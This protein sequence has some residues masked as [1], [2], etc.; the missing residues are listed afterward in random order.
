MRI[1]SLLL[2]CGLAVAGPANDAADAI[3]KAL[4]EDKPVP[5]PTAKQRTVTWLIVEVLC[6]RGELDAAEAFAKVAPGIDNEKLPAYVA[7]WRK[8]GPRKEVLEARGEASLAFNKG[9]FAKALAIIDQVKPTSSDVYSLQMLHG[10]AEVLQAVGRVAGSADAFVAAADAAIELG[11]LESASRSLEAAGSAKHSM[12]DYAKARAIWQRQ[13]EFDRRRGAPWTARTVASLGILQTEEGDHRKALEVF[14]RALKEQVETKDPNAALTR[15]YIGMAH[16]RLDEDAEALRWYEQAHKEL[17]ALGARKHAARV[18]ANIGDLHRARRRYDKAIEYYE[19]ALEVH[20][21]V[22]SPLDVAMGLDRLAT[23]HE[24]Q[25][26]YA[27]ALECFRAA[28]AEARAANLRRAAAEYGRD[29][30]RML[31]RLGRPQEAVPRLLEARRE[32]EEIGDRQGAAQTALRLGETHASLLNHG[33]ALRWYRKAATEFRELR[34]QHGLAISVA[35]MGDAHTGLG[36]YDQATKF[37]QEALQ[38]HREAKNRQGVAIVHSHLA[39]LHYYRSRFDKA[40]EYWNRA[41]ESHRARGDRFNTAAILQSVGYLHVRL[42]DF[43]AAEKCLREALRLQQEMGVSTH[44]TVELIG[45]VH[46]ARGEYAKALKLLRQGYEGHRAAGSRARA[47]IAL[48]RIGATQSSM[49]RYDD[50]IR[51]LEQARRELQALKDR[52]NAAAALREIGAVHNKRS[53]YKTAL[54]VLEGAFAECKAIDDRAEMA[55]TLLELGI[56]HKGLHNNAEALRLHELAYSKIREA[57]GRSLAATALMSVGD[58]HRRMGEFERALRCYREARSVQLAL[59]RRKAAARTL[60]SMASVHAYKGEYAKALRLY[61]QAIAETRA[62]K[63]PLG[64]LWNGLGTMYSRL[65]DPDKALE[66]YERC[67]REKIAAKDRDATSVLL[68]MAGSYRMRGDHEGALALYQQVTKAWRDAGDRAGVASALVGRGMVHLDRKE[69]AKARE[70]FEAALRE[71]PAA[72]P[73]LRMR[74]LGFVA[75]AHFFLHDYAKALELYRQLRAEARKVG[76]RTDLVTTLTNMAHIHVMLDKQLKARELA[77]EAVAELPFVI[78]GLADE[79]GAQVRQRFSRAFDVGAAACMNLRDF[80]GACHFLE[81]GRAGTLLE[82]LSLRQRLAESAIPEP[83]RAAERAAR[84]KERR[85][86]ARYRKALDDGEDGEAPF[87]QVEAARRELLETTQR[88]QRE[89]K[90]QAAL[91]YPKA[92]PLVAIRRSLEPGDALL[93]YTLLPKGSAAA[94]VIRRDGARSVMLGLAATITKAAEQFQEAVARPDERGVNLPA[95]KSAMHLAKRLRKLIIEPLQ[96]RGDTRRLL[97]SP[98]GLLSYLPFAHLVPDREVAYV[99]SGTVYKQ[100]LEADNERGEQILALGDPHY[101]NGLTPLPESRA[102]AKAVG[103]VTLLGEQATIAGLKTSLAKQKRWRA[104]HFACHGLVNP[105]RPALSS[106]ALTPGKDDDGFLRCLDVYR[107]KIPADLV[108]LSACETG[109]GKVYRSEG[110]MGWTRAFM[111]AGAPRVMVSLW[112]VDDQATR[113]LMV[114]FYELWK[115][116]AGAADALRKAQEFVRAHEKWSH[117][118]FWAAWQLWGLAE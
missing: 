68:N 79:E 23:V 105:D 117:P 96:L 84:S 88:I 45:A 2:F 110:V 85:A 29:V 115:G 22:K 81:S 76:D 72:E 60:G 113:A 95:H 57:G 56:A 80:A 67:Y 99:P 54:R 50:A 35:G 20:R 108:V 63:G 77:R 73:H 106:L 34:D 18:A 3:L 55:A 49:Q 32:Q 10:R 5:A 65:G 15:S 101:G 43:P 53:D 92:A 24:L 69:F 62:A 13:L 51:T 48:T 82:G 94:L 4:R 31:Y 116:G 41:L 37:M 112:K 100:L 16:A 30:G 114:K 28:R 78:G 111:F 118:Y 39:T 86:L 21:A 44:G 102:E 59:P 107:M 47:A 25:R 9:D 40:L 98:D 12:G 91:L 36:E 93:L 27:K 90:A 52:R 61:E 109:K 71:T 33:D 8:G 89:A 66:C 97:I 17:G 26:H 46:R 70:L 6:Q 11:W 104:V 64:E 1:L 83:L 74:V 38:L 7:W 19:R 87:K 14:H 42:G 75:E 103:R 58:I